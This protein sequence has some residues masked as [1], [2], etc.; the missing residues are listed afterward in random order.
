MVLDPLDSS[1]HDIDWLISR[2]ASEPTSCMISG[3]EQSRAALNK[4]HSYEK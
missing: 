1:A 4:A 2:L 3:E